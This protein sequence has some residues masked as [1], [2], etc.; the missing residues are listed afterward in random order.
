MSGLDQSQRQVVA[1]FHQVRLQS[2]RR[3]EGWD[4]TVQSFMLAINR[5]ECVPGAGCGMIADG[6]QQTRGDLTFPAGFKAG[7]RQ[8]RE[9]WRQGGADRWLLL[10]LG[11]RRWC[12][13]H[14]RQQGKKPE[15]AEYQFPPQGAEGLA[16]P[17]REEKLMSR[18]RFHAAL[19]KPRRSPPREGGSSSCRRS[20]Y[21]SGAMAM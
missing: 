12:R 13:G 19:R 10:R 21:S 4:G 5:A 16:Y 17:A 14:A 7:F 2:E 15:N 18:G 9:R 1:S 6:F 20:H 8:D 3:L 11:N